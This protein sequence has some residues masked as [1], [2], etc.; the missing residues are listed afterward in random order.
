[1]EKT[2][3]GL[4]A[5]MGALTPLAGAQ[6]TAMTSEEANRALQVTSLAELLEPAP[7]ALAVL[8]ALDAERK[9]EPAAGEAKGVQ[10][11]YHHHHHHHHHFYHHHHHHHHYYYYPHHH[12]HHYYYY[13]HHHHHHHN[14]LGWCFTHP[15]AC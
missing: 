15:W 3:I 5:A 8:I 14:F 7:N 13:H 10:L 4:V 12:H 11:A 6:A 2:V 1:M 9:S